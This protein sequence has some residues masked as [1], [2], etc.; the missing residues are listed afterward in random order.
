MQSEGVG[1]NLR[2]KQNWLELK[3]KIKMDLQA[4]KLKQVAAYT[5][6]DLMFPLKL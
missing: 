1:F 3:R 5:P 2:K 6:S 4:G